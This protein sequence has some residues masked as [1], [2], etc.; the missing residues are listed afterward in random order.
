M[1]ENIEFIY[2]QEYWFISAFINTDEMT[3]KEKAEEI[4]ELILKRLSNSDYDYFQRAFRFFRDILG[5]E[6]KKK[7]LIDMTKNITIE[8]DWVPYFE[9][10]PYTNE[11]K[12]YTIGNKDLV[13][14]TLGYFQFKVEY[15]RNDPLKKEG[16]TADL[17]QQVPYAVLNFLKEF[18]SMPKNDYIYIDTQSPIYVF[19]TSNK[20]KPK[21]I[22]WTQESINKHKRILGS[23]I[24]IYSG[25]WP[26]YNERIFDERIKNNL[27][28]R[29]SELH[30][31][32]RN[33]GFVYMT[34]ENYP[35]FIDYME[36]FVIYSTP[37]IRAMQFALMSINQS[38]DILLMKYHSDVF[39][40]L[41]TIEMKIKN[42]RY[43]RG[44]I[45]TKLSLI[46]NELDW[47]R[48]Q[49][50][51]SVLKHLIIQFNLDDLFNRV[52]RKFKIIYDSMQELY[53]KKNEENQ[54]RTERGLSLLNL[55]FGAGI[56]ADFAAIVMI[57]L[58]L[59]EGDFSTILLNSIIALI[60][61]GILI[62]TII[63]FMYVRIQ[64]KG[65]E[66]GMT[67]D[68]VIEDGQGNIILIKR[69]YPPYEG[70]YALP[71]GFISYEEKPQQ[72]LIREVREETNLIVKIEKKIGTF[73]E[74]NRDPRGKIISKAFKC[75]IIG[76][77][78]RMESGDDSSDIERIPINKLK[79]IDLAFDHKKILKQANLL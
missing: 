29:L 12:P 42:L 57:A 73:D 68:A 3:G 48:R 23:W 74:P 19:A 14:N 43:L 9:S 49:H 71:G 7:Q 69:K 65:E 79:D 78:S 53:I 33:S 32:R 35:K 54:K 51:T 59:Q 63:Y 10:F 77:L 16:I 6:D 44:M 72:A 22:Q 11:A 58:S 45:Q 26:D 17:I 30:F 28:N 52:N 66:V 62:T 20:T 50:Y 2:H 5:G 21:E 39:M 37:K 24:Q 40:T 38:L 27:S 41:K 60:I 47:N 4:K 46:Y 75:S 36:E 8:C 34:E 67:V 61:G 18:C 55:L 1:A 31:I 13:F 25:Q 70:K 56:L 15:Y 64:M 76:D